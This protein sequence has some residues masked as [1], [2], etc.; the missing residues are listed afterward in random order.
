VKGPKLE[1]KLNFDAKKAQ[2]WAKD[3]LL[4]VVLGGAS[5]AALAG[6]YFAADMMTAT[7]MEEA[8]GKAARMSELK[9]LE[10]TQ[11]TLEVP[12][13]APF[14][15]NA[16]VNQKLLE[17]YQSRIDTLR[18]DS[19]Q[20]REFAVAR[21]KGSHQPVMA[22]RLQ[23]GDPTLEQIHLDFFD[24]ISAAYGTLLSQSRLGSVPDEA[25][26]QAFLVRRKEQ[27]ISSDLKKGP[28]EQLNS[29]EAEALARE[30]GNARLQAYNEAARDFAIYADAETL[31]V[32]TAPFKKDAPDVILPSLWR[33]QWEFWVL[34]DILAAFTAVNG[35]D[36]NVQTAAVKRIDEV[37]FIGPIGAGAAAPA[38]AD[39]AAPA[40]DGSGADGT[41][42]DGSMGDG[43][44][45]A[46]AGMV[47]A[48]IDPAMPVAL[49]NFSAS[50]TGR[51]TN[52]LY[53]VFASDVTFVCETARI[54][55]VFDA[56]AKQNFIT[57]TMASIRPEDPF[58]A[59]EDGYIYGPAHVSLVRLRLESVWLREWTGPL[60]PDPVRKRLGTS[61]TLAGAAPA[62]GD[63]PADAG[64]TNYG[65]GG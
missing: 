11:V 61:G 24:A 33:Q 3:N 12:G 60:M 32:P 14:A 65:Q 55:Q 46:G 7:V 58:E 53:D 52:Q 51:R 38:G 45:P 6:G 42:S 4:L 30:L 34:S 63:L 19:A 27:F 43:S 17:E 50:F 31:R 56:L 59:A 40:G 18:K 62:A 26:V 1:L 47:G 28:N 8:Q 5:L 48:P 41:G 16:V 64:S 2:A 23:K 57:I 44:M 29:Q 36:A 9:D 21:N 54:P 15:Q 10:R 13:Q 25:E 35:P 22:L 37:R 39:G 49:D 20:V